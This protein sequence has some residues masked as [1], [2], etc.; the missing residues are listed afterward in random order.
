MKRMTITIGIP[1]FHSEEN[2]AGLL[3]SL[4]RQKQENI[5]I[6]HI[7]VYS[8][9]SKDKTVENAKSV[10]S[11]KIKVI[12]SKKNKGFAYA[13][14]YLLKVNK[15]DVFVE[16]NDDIRIDSDSVIEEIVRPFKNKK[17]GLVGGNIKALPPKTFIGQ[18]IYTSY[19]VFLNLRLNYKKGKTDLTCDGKILALSKDFA[20]SLKLESSKVGNVDI[21]LYYEN[22]R[23]K[24]LYKFA[25][26]AVVLF[27]LPESLKDFKN[28]EKR[29]VISR[30]LM[31]KSFGELFLAEHKISKLAY[32]KSA[33]SVFFR[34]PLQSILFKLLV[35]RSSVSGK[36]S[37][38]K[39][40]LALTTKKLSLLFTDFESFW[41]A[42]L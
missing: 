42:I 6:E 26:K 3:T 5:K 39:W 27:R 13:F 24:R 41:L 32:L 9:G 14:N 25:K 17:V 11:K 19:L 7:I 40:K 30:N 31:Q 23:Q 38:I 12:N 29:S 10:K 36:K 35:N 34:Y 21:Y 28:Q 4:L 15:S 1:A 20:E 2:I 33:L 22:L 16:L 8:D 18:C 37:P